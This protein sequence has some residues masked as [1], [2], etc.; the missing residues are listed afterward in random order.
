MS[1]LVLGAMLAWRLR[2]GDGTPMERDWLERLR[3]D[4]I[5]LL[6][7]GT[8]SELQRRGVAM[9]PVAWSGLASRQHRT[10][11]RDVHADFIRAGAD[12]ITTNTFGTTRFVLE[13]AGCGEEF[14][15]INNAAV[16]AAL[17]ARQIAADRPVAIAGSI[18]CLP[19]RFD[20]AAYPSA[21]TERSAYEE[22]AQLLAQLGVDLIALEMIQDLEHGRLAMEA[23]LATGLPVCLGVSARQLDAALVCFD[24]LDRD[25]GAVV[26]SL[27]AL[28]PA[29]VNVMHTPPDDIGVALEAVKRQWRG[30]LGTYPELG[31]FAA[32][33]WQFT[34]AVSPEDLADLAV[35]W[36]GQGVRL[37]GGCCGTGPEHIAALAQARPRLLE[38]RAV[39]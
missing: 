1:R 18:S 4:D 28:G 22:L 34:D 3:C 17:E 19:P 29:V 38:A 8:G 15:I 7:G 6:D 25:F 12:I 27:I 32:P 5:V 16:E 35:G 36:V 33:D 30:P 24:Y 13:V 39:R 23:A 10:A 26:D 14:E 11:L 37:L 31:D 21:R 20:D 9:S 2:P